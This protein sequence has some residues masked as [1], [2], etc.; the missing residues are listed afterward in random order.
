MSGKKCPTRGLNISLNA[1]SGAVCSGR[2]SYARLP[3]WTLQLMGPSVA[4]SLRSCAPS[5][6]R[7]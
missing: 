2:D 7:S 1:I 5:G 3:N 4:A 6:A